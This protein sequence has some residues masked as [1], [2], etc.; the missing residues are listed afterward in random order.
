MKI[1]ELSINTVGY[2]FAW[3]LIVVIVTVGLIGELPAVVL[4]SVAFVYRY[5]KGEKQI[6]DNGKVGAL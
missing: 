2:P 1:P 6:Q 5:R 3:F 4:G